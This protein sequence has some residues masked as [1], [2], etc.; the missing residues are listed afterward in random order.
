MAR[1]EKVLMVIDLSQY[2][3]QE[4]FQI[5][6]DIQNLNGKGIT[7]TFLEDLNKAVQAELETRTEPT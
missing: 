7:A 5:R 6:D 4:L 1:K 2:N 3:I